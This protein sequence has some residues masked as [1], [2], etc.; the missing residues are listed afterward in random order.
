[1]NECMAYN[2][3]YIYFWQVSELTSF[4]KMKCKKCQ[5]DNTACKDFCLMFTREI[6]KTLPSLYMFVSF[7]LQTKTGRYQT[8]LGYTLYLLIHPF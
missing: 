2:S 3:H 6:D 4:S 7:N 1:M 5:I 8:L